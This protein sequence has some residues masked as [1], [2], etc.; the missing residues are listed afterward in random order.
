MAIGILELL[1]V[2]PGIEAGGQPS[3]AVISPIPSKGVDR[4]RTG[5]SPHRGPLDDEMLEAIVRASTPAFQVLGGSDFGGE[6]GL[7]DIE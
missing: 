2:Y 1:S 4:H 5:A 7:P 3:G 6:T